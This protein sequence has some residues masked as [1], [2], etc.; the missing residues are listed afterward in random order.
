MY[1]STHS[2]TVIQK[3]ETK[4]C[5]FSNDYWDA[6][7][8]LHMILFNSERAIVH[9]FSLYVLSLD[10]WMGIWLSSLMYV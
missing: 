6:F 8:K 7:L 1:A 5:S 3:A 9:S 10:F 2:P 4:Y